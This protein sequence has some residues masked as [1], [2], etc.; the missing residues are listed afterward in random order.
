MMNFYERVVSFISFL[1]HS[2][3]LMVSYISSTYSYK[4]V[5][6]FLDLRDEESRLQ[7]FHTLIDTLPK[8]NQDTLE[9]LVFHLAR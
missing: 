4:I 6:F 9:R 7:R 1:E 3:G 2:F 8:P 5:Y